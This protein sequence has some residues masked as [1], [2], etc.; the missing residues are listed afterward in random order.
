MTHAVQGAQGARRQ[1]RRRRHLHERDHAAGR[2]RRADPARHRRR[3]RLRGD[4]LPVS[5]RQGRPR[6]SRSLYRC[7]GRAGS[8]ICAAARRNG[9]RASPAATSTPSRPSPRLIGERKRAYFR[10]GYGFARSRNGAANMHA[11]S[12]IAAVTGAWRLEGGGAFHNNAAIYHWNKTMIEG[13]DVRDPSVRMLDQSRIGAILC[14]EEDALARRT[15]GH[16]DAGAEHQS[17]LGR[18]RPGAGQAR[19]C[20]RRPVR[21]RARAVHDRDGRN[22]RYRAAGDHVP[23]ARRRLSGRR[24]PA[25]P[26]RAEAGR[27]A[28]RVPLEPRGD[29]LRWRRASA[30]GTRAST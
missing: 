19:L 11:A 9:P 21:V 10:L 12:C 3:A 16:R 13:H 26:A 6:L 27:A 1:D 22:G 25:H 7:A 14:G 2:S 15:A 4:A 20:P 17:G 18:A 29:L 28:R 5:R 8:S 23:G 24:P 30:R